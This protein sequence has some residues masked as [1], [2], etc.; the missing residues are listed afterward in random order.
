MSRIGGMSLADLQRESE[1][2]WAKGFP[3]KAMTK[4][5]D[6]GFIQSKPKGEKAR[7]RGHDCGQ[8]RKQG[9]SGRIPCRRLSLPSLVLPFF[10]PFPHPPHA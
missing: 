8:G 2:L 5:E 4:L 10:N 7:E 1:S 6:Y 3:E 9:D